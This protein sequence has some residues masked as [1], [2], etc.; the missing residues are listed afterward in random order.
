MESRELMRREIRESA[1][2]LLASDMPFLGGGGDGLV[3]DVVFD[4]DHFSLRNAIPKIFPT[5]QPHP[6]HWWRYGVTGI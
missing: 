3:A 5:I 4:A 1:V 2:Q 6:M